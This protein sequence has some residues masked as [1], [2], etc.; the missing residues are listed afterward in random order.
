MIMMMVSV[1]LLH[2]TLGI[3]KWIMRTVSKYDTV[4]CMMLN[5]IT[6]YE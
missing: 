1:R 5:P 2:N 3:V 4:Y 6:Y